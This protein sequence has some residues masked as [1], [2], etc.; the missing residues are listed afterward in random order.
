M[1]K[2]YWRHIP[3]PTIL[4]LLSSV[5]IA[6][7]QS[8]PEIVIPVSDA[9]ARR[10]IEKTAANERKFERYRWLSK[11][12][13]RIVKINRAAMQLVDEPVLFT[14]FAEDGPIVVMSNGVEDH[15]WSASRIAGRFDSEAYG[16]MARVIAD[17]PGV[18]PV[19][20]E[21]ALTGAVKNTNN[22]SL[23]VASVPQDPDTGDVLLRPEQAQEYAINPANGDLKRL[24]WIEG[25]TR[26]LAIREGFN[27]CE[28][29]S[30]H[31]EGEVEWALAPDKND[32]D[33]IVTPA[34]GAALCEPMGDVFEFTK[35]LSAESRAMWPYDDYRR[36]RPWPDNVVMTWQASGNIS[37]D[38]MGRL[39]K[40]KPLNGH[41]YGVKTLP[42]SPGYTMIYEL[43]Q[44]WPATDMPID[45]HL[46]PAE[47]EAERNSPRMVAH[48]KTEAYRLEKERNDAYK[49][50]ME[51]AEAR[52]QARGN[53]SAG[54]K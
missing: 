48:R 16:G 44:K 40:V 31:T 11:D 13:I 3:C 1:R 53:A 19:L 27:L 5:G 6:T 49:A 14:A 4:M 38:G 30:S 42:N 12:R 8:Y 34:D 41:H 29:D 32:Q 15:K 17:N 23:Y 39:S 21:Q 52:I 43:A 36:A 20:L 50:H 54:D 9:E 10:V 25:S 47:L 22:V 51:A 46:T 2:K 26:N 7:A 37:T 33:T 18:D 35:R 28:K 45:T 24:E